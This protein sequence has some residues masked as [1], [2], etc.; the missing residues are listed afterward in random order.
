ML[1]KE[2]INALNR[3]S[4][5]LSDKAVSESLGV[6]TDQRH[7]LKS[8]QAK[9]N[10]T[11]LAHTALELSEASLSFTDAEKAVVQ[12]FGLDL[13]FSKNWWLSRITFLSNDKERSSDTD[14]WP[15]FSLLRSVVPLLVPIANLL[16]QE[17]ETL[18]EGMGADLQIVFPANL[19]LT[20]LKLVTALEAID[21]LCKEIAAIDNTHTETVY[22]RRV[23]SGSPKL[24]ELAS[25]SGSA[26]VKVGKLVGY[27]AFKLALMP[28][29]RALKEIEV[30]SKGTDVAADIEDRVKNGTLTRH[31]ADRHLEAL[32]TTLS[33]LFATGATV[34]GAERSAEVL[35]LPQSEPQLLLE[36]PKGNAQPE[37]QS[38]ADQ[39]APA[40]KVKPKA[41]GAKK[42]KA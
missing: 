2:L 31:Q 3:I 5:I 15:A 30:I 12:T 41:R 38:T 4:E 16:E 28:Q 1:R 10:F 34:S 42:K 23:D 40:K 6:M 22:I 36:G 18:E 17:V 11:I 9:I 20:S 26:L 7:G 33:K 24:I 39:E 29:S 14:A 35:A 32:N 25:R 37:K 27:M 21:E 13:F 8:E 19:A